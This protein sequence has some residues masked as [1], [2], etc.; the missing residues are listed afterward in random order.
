MT[1]IYPA[2]YGPDLE[3]K[4]ELERRWS[5]EGRHLEVVGYRAMKRDEFK[6]QGYRMVEAR[7]MAWSEAA[8]TYTSGVSPESGPSLECT[9]PVDSKDVLTDTSAEALFHENLG[10]AHF[11]EEV[12]WV[13][14]NLGNPRL[15]MS[16]APSH[17]SY[18]L[19]EWAK[20]AQDK[21]F[22]MYERMKRAERDRETESSLEDTVERKRLDDL[23]AL[24]KDFVE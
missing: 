19:L 5:S 9:S 12:C 11:E 13:Y 15:D 7:D 14:A 18:G 8:D 16:T 3:T 2:K 4:M 6:K 21:F 17:G 10:S 20:S 1:D 23:E 24:L 22:G